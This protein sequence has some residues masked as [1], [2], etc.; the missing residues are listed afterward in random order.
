[1]GKWGSC[2]SL[3]TNYLDLRSSSNDVSFQKESV[4]SVGLD[5]ITKK[6]GFLDV[7]GTLTLPSTLY[8]QNLGYTTFPEE[9]CKIATYGT[10]V[11]LDELN[12]QPPNKDL[13]LD[14]T[15]LPGSLFLKSSAS[16]G[17]LLGSA[18]I[19]STPPEVAPTSSL[20][21]QLLAPWTE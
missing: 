19:P 4:W 5:P 20:S 8:Y 15:T 16:R 18:V 1:M 13:F 11:G 7:K 12:V 10:L 17:L 2:H 6:T 14:S 9:G 3:A 21:V